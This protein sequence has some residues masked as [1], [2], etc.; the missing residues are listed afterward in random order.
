MTEL[1]RVLSWKIFS[2]NNAHK[3]FPSLLTFGN[4]RHSEYFKL[5]S[6]LVFVSFCFHLNYAT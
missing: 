3:Y 2:P 1:I 5:C 6:R 4:D